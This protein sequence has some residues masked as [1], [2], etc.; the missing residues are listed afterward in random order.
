MNKFKK[1]HLLF[2][3][4][5]LTLCCVLLPRNCPCAAQ[6]AAEN[7]SVDLIECGDRDLQ[8]K[9]LCNPRWPTTKKEN[10]LSMILAQTESGEITVTVSK[11]F[12]RGLDYQDL[13]PVALQRVYGYADYFK[14]ARTRIDRK[15]VIRIEGHPR[16]NHGHHLLDYL[17]LQDTILYRVSYKAST[18]EDYRKYLPV[19][20]KMMRNFDFLGD[21]K[22][23]SR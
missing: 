1:K 8:I 10:Q 13:T 5:I 12:E 19:F 9:I 6:P 7:K 17:L 23:I 15:P 11:S 18:Y 14:Y 3:Q 16:D 21:E 20:V 4:L 2:V 22:K